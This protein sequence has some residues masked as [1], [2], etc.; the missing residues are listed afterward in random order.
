MAAVRLFGRMVARLLFY[1]RTSKYEN[2]TTYDKYA[3]TQFDIS[4]VD[5]AVQFMYY[6]NE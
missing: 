6:E 3:S 5:C 2:E 4:F 1:T